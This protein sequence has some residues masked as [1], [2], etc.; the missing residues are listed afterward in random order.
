MYPVVHGDLLLYSFEAI[1]CLIGA[2][3]AFLSYLT[4]AR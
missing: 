2:I 3:V 4:L 1:A